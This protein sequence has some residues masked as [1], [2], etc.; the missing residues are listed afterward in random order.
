MHMKDVRFQVIE[1]NIQDN[2]F[3]FVSVYGKNLESELISETSGNFKRLLVSLAAGA[4]DE[5]GVVDH[6]TA[7][8]DAT[9]LLRAGE[10]RAGTDESTFNMVFCQ[11]NFGQIKLVSGNLIKFENIF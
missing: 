11:R 2:D 7:N 5:S 9:E 1:D 3:I 10:L 6:E 8:R 4:R